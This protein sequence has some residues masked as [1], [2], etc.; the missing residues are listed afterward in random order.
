MLVILKSNPAIMLTQFSC[1]DVRNKIALYQSVFEVCQLKL[2]MIKLYKSRLSKF[3]VLNTNKY[4]SV[5]TILYTGTAQMARV[6]SL[7]ALVAVN[8]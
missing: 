4:H 3:S 1:L 8:S 6:N 5:P 2:I 7:P